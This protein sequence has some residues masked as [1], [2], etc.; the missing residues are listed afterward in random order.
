VKVST[1]DGQTVTWQADGQIPV[2]FGNRAKLKVA[3]I[4]RQDTR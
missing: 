1:P 4:L 3:D 2:P